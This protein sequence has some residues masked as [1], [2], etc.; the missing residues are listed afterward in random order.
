MQQNLPQT[1]KKSS[2]IR[3][4]VILL[5]ALLIAK[6]IA[7]YTGKDMA[8]MAIKAHKSEIE[9][10][11]A[12]D[13]LTTRELL[14]KMCAHMDS[15]APKKMDNQTTFLS[16]SVLGNDTIQ[17]NYSIN[18]NSKR[19]NTA[20]V[21]RAAT[22]NLKKNW[23]NLGFEKEGIVVIYS[24]GDSLGKFWFKETL[25]PSNHYKAE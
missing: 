5:I 2:L 17:Y 10:E 23:S 14:Y 9:K 6:V 7:Y 3:N 8:D 22:E 12:A 11:I 16:A 18:V 15:S 1:K 19:Y 13:T 21:K 20:I 24:Y 25:S 4:I